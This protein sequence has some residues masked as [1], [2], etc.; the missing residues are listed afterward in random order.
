MN[1][2]RLEACL[3]AVSSML[4][5]LILGVCGYLGARQGEV[6]AVSV[7]IMREVM[8][9]ELHSSLTIEETRIRLE[10]RRKEEIALLDS[11]IDQTDS[12]DRSRSDAHEQKMQI[13]QRME[14]EAKTE[15]SLAYM[16]FD[17]AAAVCGAQ[18]LTV[19]IPFDQAKDEKTRVRLIDAAASSSGISPEAVKIILTKI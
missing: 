19:F 12:G 15:A 17:R 6:K 10:E 9:Q 16:G 13:V 7:P 5:L 1:K 3:R 2:V 11:V 14:I 4:L 18:S 8:E